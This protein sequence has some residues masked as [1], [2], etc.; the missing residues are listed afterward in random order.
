MS[1]QDEQA[2]QGQTFERPQRILPG[3]GLPSSAGDALGQD[4]KRAEEALRESEERFRLVARATSDAI[5]D[6]DLVTGA[7]WWSEGARN[8]F[9]YAPGDV[10]PD[11]TWWYDHIHPEDS[12]RVVGGIYAVIRGGA[13]FWR[14]AYRYRR[15]D[16]SYAYVVDR[17]YVIHDG[18]GKPVRMIGGMTDITE[19]KRAEEALRES[20]ERFRRLC[21]ASF[22]GIAIHDKGK[23][24]DANQTLA[25][26]LGCELSEVIGMDGLELVARESRDF[27]LQ[28]ILSGYEN[29]YEALCLRK[30]GSMFVSEFRS[31]AVPYDG[32]M[33]R[34]TAIR[35]VS[36]RKRAEEA[37][38]ESEERFRLVARSTSDAVWDHDLLTSGM[39]WS[40]GL[41]ALFGYAPSEVGPDVRWWHDHIHPEDSARVVAGIYEVI[42]AGREVWSDEYR[43]LR[44]NG[45]YARVE[46]RG[47]IMRDCDGKPVRMIGGVTG[48]T[49]RKR[50]EEELRETRDYLEKLIDYANAPIIVWDPSFTITRFN[51]AFER[52]T[53]RLANQVIG[54]RLE[55]LFPEH[56]R[57]ASMEQIARTLRG[58][59]WELIE[60]P[61]LHQSG[62]VR[63]VLWNSANI[64]GADGRTVVATIAQGTD[65]TDRK[66]AEEGL[67]ENENKFR[68]VLNG[69]RDMVYC[70]NLKTFAYDYVS[71]SCSEVLGYSPEEFAALGFMGAGSL[72]HPDDVR[73]VLERFAQLRTHPTVEYRFRHKELG[74]RWMSDARSVVFDDRGGAAVVGTLRDVTERKRAEEALRES[75]RRYRLLAENATDII[76]TRDMNLRVT[77][78]SPAVTRVRG[79][80]AEELMAQTLEEVLTPA[81]LEVAMKAVAEELA[82]EKMEQKDLFRSRTLEL[83]QY[84]KDGS[85][86]WLEVRMTF[87]RDEDKRIVGILGISRDISERKRAE[88]AL[89]ESEERF[90]R[91]A[92]ASFEGI[93]IHD[94]GKILDANRTCAQMFG[95]EVSEAIGMDALDFAAP[96]FR[97]LALQNVLS[98][99]EKPYEALVV[100]R[101]GLTF[102]AEVCAKA[103]PYDGRMVRVVAVRDISERKRAEEALQQAREE[104]ESRV[105]RQVQRGNAYGLTFR[106]L[107][108]L[109]LVAAGESDKEIAT[110]LGISP[111]TAHK[112]LANILH[113]MGA[114]CRTEAGV[115]ALREELLD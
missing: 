78:V 47:H 56:E 36:E 95:Y 53:G 92:E 18:G 69:A 112:H 97:D 84:C 9:G 106:E 86:V 107:T 54:Q 115:R 63:Q 55:V 110:V 31:K 100:R 103:V 72:V 111:L 57:A 77:Y 42:R 34:V 5:W 3:D 28:N 7:V 51:D 90:R 24:L 4:G 61:I 65:I 101:D 32:R 104:L 64:T 27:V 76:W 8:L 114:V 43:F 83:E 75:E 46:D 15:A 33:L 108:V 59:F 19:R 96:E 68:H 39:W 60:I 113:K 2:K 20:E 10:G 80:S 89:R 25:T 13:E 26:M 38:R 99:H 74:Y 40:E 21:E 98:G 58:E 17:G 14:D 81:S 67:R 79:Y 11:A 29:P 93:V 44:A 62:E 1:P 50:A 88:E 102:W 82:I 87:L 66:R 35:D 45:S 91:L 71:P 41:R 12:D 6:W 30:D 73:P 37:L 70:L 105:E 52:L 16:G 22:E 109:H 48:I 94:K 23:I 85:T 49:E